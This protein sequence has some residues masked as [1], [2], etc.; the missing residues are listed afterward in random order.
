[1]YVACRSVERAQQAVDDIV[2]QT[3]VSGSQLPIL[4]LNL[5]SFKSIRS[6]ASLFK[7]SKH[8][9]YDFNYDTTQ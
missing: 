2:N 8:L 7:Q 5:A 6:F 4:Q 9:I 3:G 1:M